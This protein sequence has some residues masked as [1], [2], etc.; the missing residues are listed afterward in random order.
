MR[1]R[2][3]GWKEEMKSETVTVN[4]EWTEAW[5]LVAAD[6]GAVTCPGRGGWGEAGEK[7]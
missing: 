5:T 3:G 1:P 2:G 6:G 4:N 7:G